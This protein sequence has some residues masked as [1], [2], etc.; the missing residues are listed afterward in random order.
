MSDIPDASEDVTDYTEIGE[1]DGLGSGSLDPTTGTSDDLHDVFNVPEGPV[2]Q[3]VSGVD[4]GIVRVGEQGEDLAHK[5]PGPETSGGTKEPAGE[6]DIE[7][8]AP[9]S[10]SG[11]DPRSTGGV[12]QVVSHTRGEGPVSDP[13]LEPVEF[14]FLAAGVPHSPAGTFGGRYPERVR[15]TIQSHMSETSEIFCGYVQVQ[16]DAL[17]VEPT[18]YFEAIN[19]PEAEK[20][21]NAMQDEMNSLHALGTWSYVVVND[22]QKKKALPVKWVYKIKLSETGEIERFKARLVAKGFKQVYGIDY[23]EVYAPVSRHT[24]LRYLLSKAVQENMYVHQMDVSTAFLH[25]NL[26]EEVHVQQPEGFHVGGP[27]TVCKLHKALYGL[28]QAPRAWYVTISDVLKFSEFSISDADP[29]LFVQ[30]LEGNES[31]FLLLYVDDILIVSKDMSCIDKVKSLLSSKFAVKD[32]GEARHF[33][34]MQ[35]TMKRD[36]S[37]IL[38]SIKLSNEKLITDILDSFDMNVCSP[39]AVPLDLS[40]K[41]MKGVG[42]ALPKENRYRELVGYCTLPTQLGLICL[43]LLGC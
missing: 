32:L 7:V 17:I 25:G 16:K 22:K 40:W 9:C 23:T 10:T 36:A 29:S 5:E 3:A 4:G 8:P 2:G 31:V 20:W 28:K 37:G 19:S 43:L 21:L 18:T 34:G 27:N 1:N 33:L 6:P 41:L 35:I 26:H 30:Q 38:E 42:D 13:P 15:N 11:L 39:K 14:D 24:T 12:P